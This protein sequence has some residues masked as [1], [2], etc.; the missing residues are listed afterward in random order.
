MNLAKSRQNV[1]DDECRQEHGVNN[2]F[3]GDSFYEKVL[4]LIICTLSLV[5]A[6]LGAGCTGPGKDGASYRLQRTDSTVTPQLPGS[7]T[8]SIIDAGA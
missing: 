3:C 8:G 4:S 1:Y 6:A 2:A 5:T 7:L